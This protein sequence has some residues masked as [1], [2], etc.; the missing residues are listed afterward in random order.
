MQ[1]LQTL[2]MED[3]E[4]DPTGELQRGAQLALQQEIAADVERRAE[5]AL[6][7]EAVDR[8]MDV[9]ARDPDQARVMLNLMEMGSPIDQIRDM[10]TKYMILQREIDRAQ[11]AVGNQS[12]VRHA[13]DFLL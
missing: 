7:R 8:I 11:I 1:A 6:E 2:A 13:A 9:A 4:T 10:N 5:A 12:W 3:R